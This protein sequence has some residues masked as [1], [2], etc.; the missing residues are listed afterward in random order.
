MRPTQRQAIEQARNWIAE[1]PE[2]R[3]QSA[4]AI[5]AMLNAALAETAEPVALTAMQQ[6][7]KAA[8]H[9]HAWSK[10]YTTPQP[11]APAETAE[12]VAWSQSFDAWWAENRV[13]THQIKG[14]EGFARKAFHAGVKVT[15][16]QPPAPA[17]ELT[18]EEID[19]LAEHHR[20][21]YGHLFDRLD[22]QVFARAAIAAHEARKGGL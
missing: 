5:V 20:N 22:L 2:D 15:S 14:A 6:A 17:V 1:R 18:D 16:H 8:A 19:A 7:G 4:G 10:Q 13:A 11:P 3:K 21:Y 9:Y 12:P